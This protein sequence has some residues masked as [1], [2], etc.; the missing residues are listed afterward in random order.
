MAN[1]LTVSC[2]ADVWTKVATNATAG[3]VHKFYDDDDIADPT[4]Y[5][6]TYRVSGEAAPTSKDEGVVC[7]YESN[8]EIIESSYGID[9]YIMPIDRA[10][11]VRVDI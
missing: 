7:F 9:V 4:A 6:Q 10:G 3:M 5:L 1:P 8:S 11:S 2:P